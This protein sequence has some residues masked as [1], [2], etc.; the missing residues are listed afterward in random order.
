MTD[1]MLQEQIHIASG[2]CVMFY[3]NAFW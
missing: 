2:M 1:F 3:V